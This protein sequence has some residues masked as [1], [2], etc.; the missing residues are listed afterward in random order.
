MNLLTRLA[1]N[2]LWILIARIEAQTDIS[3]TR[4]VSHELPDLS[5]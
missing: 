5:R 2:S 1:R 4:G 3:H